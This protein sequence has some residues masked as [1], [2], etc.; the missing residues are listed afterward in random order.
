MA[1]A[2][3]PQTYIRHQEAIIARP[4]SRPDSRPDLPGIKVP[5][6]VVVGDSDT[7]T[8]PE[9]AKEMAAGIPGAKLVIIPNAGHMALVEQPEVVTAATAKWLKQFPPHQRNVPRGS[10]ERSAGPMSDWEPR[11]SPFGDI[12]N[13]NNWKGLTGAS[14]GIDFR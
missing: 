4:D 3:G 14:R 5:T 9:A 10:V 11:N 6:L 1:K 2:N 8:I 13:T 7:I 12:L